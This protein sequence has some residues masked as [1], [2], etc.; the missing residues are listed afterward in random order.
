M[1]HSFS[2]SAAPD[3]NLV[4]SLGAIIWEAHPITFQFTY[5]NR[6]AEKLL[7]YSIED[8]LS[9]P[10][11]W[12]ELVH[13][14]DRDAAVAMR[15]AAVEEGRDH[16]FEYRVIAADGSIRWLRDI[17][18]AGRG[19]DGRCGRLCGV[20]IDLTEAKVR[21]EETLHRGGRMEALARVT[22]AVAHDLRNVFTVVQVNG[23]L[24]L[25]TD[26]GADVRLELTAICQAATLGREIIEQLSAFGRRHRCVTVVDV[27]GAVS[28]TRNLLDRL[29]RPVGEL[30]ID[31]SAAQSWVL[32]ENGGVQQILLN[33]VIN[34]REA[35]ASTGGRVTIVTRNISASVPGSPR[36][37]RD[38]VELE[39]SDTGA[40]MPP[41]VRERIFELH[42]T[43]K[44][45]R[46]GAGIGLATVAAIVREAAGTISVESEPHAGTTFRIR[47][48]TAPMTS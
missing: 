3:R 41:H 19:E 10:T 25:A 40:G 33:L 32:M 31:A 39:V 8:W 7:G 43:T 29:I 34:A 2:A 47:L 11:F 9:R 17:V 26:A 35:M 5:V 30:V 42:F 1:T 23:E 18:S 46:R 44:E 4:E 21:L 14:D 27:N 38:F 16:D 13:P 28:N 37:M 24:A 45:E 12:T 48:P 15:R 22:T 6:A 36:E 20:M